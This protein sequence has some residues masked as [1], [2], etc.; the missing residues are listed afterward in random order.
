MIRAMRTFG[1]TTAVLFLL[2]CSNTPAQQAGQQ[3]PASTDTS[4]AARIGDR[5]ITVQELEERWR[6]QNAAERAQATQAVYDGRR[7]A[8]E[9][10]VADMLLEQAAKAGGVSVDEY[11]KTETAKRVK[12][13]T[14][15]EVVSFF[16]ANQGQMQGRGMAAMSPLIRQFLE[17]QQQNAARGALIADLKKTGPA[18][19]VLLEAPRHVVEV[20]ADDAVLGPANAPVTLVE[21]S[22]FQRPFCQRVTP[23]MKR[24]RETYGDRVR[25]VWK[26]FPLTQIHPEAFKAAEAGHCAR[27]QGKFWE[28]HDRLF[29]NQQ[30]L[31]P[32]QLKEHAT[33][34]G[35]DAAKFNACLDTAKYGSRVQ[36]NVEAGQQ[37]G[38][39]STPSA[40]INGRAVTGALP[41]EA[42]AAVI[43]EELARAAR[44]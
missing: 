42:F 31:L 9:S 39:N 16:Q 33:A 19:N 10:I 30:T 32:D 20:T 29:A 2:A 36:A 1:A 23:T 26:D 40:F 44:K 28:F 15:G 12:P 35:I 27:E 13:V 24:I 18:L 22:D 11:V 34:V 21:F 38:V 7:N 43:D 4:V 3:P 6:Q 17:G 25:I 14:D 5:T 41:Y 8:L 37:L